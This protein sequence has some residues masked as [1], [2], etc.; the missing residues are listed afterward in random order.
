[1]AASALLFALALAGCRQESL[2]STLELTERAQEGDPRPFLLGF[3]DVP[4]ELTEEAYASQF[5]F[6][7]NYG[8]AILLQR[9]PTWSDFLPRASVSSA[10]RDEVLAAREAARARNLSLVVALDPFDPANRARLDNLP[11]SYEGRSLADPDLRRAFVAEAEFIARNMRPDYL[12]LGTEVN[13]TFE[14]NPEGYFAFVDAYRDAYDVVKEASPQTQVLVTYQYEE[15]LGVVPELPPHAPRWDLL[16]D[17]GARLDVLGITSYPSFA[18]PTARK[19]PAEYYLQLREH[20]DRSVAFVGVGFSSGAH[21]SGV[22]ASTE[23]EQRRFLQRLLEDA[24]RMQSPLLIWFA[25]QDF[26][27]ATTAPYD[28][29]ATIGLRNPNGTP[30]EAWSVWETASRRPVDAEAAAAL[31]AA[32]EAAEAAATPSPTPA[33]EDNGD[34]AGET[35]ADAEET[36]VEGAGDT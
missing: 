7:A 22:N 18:Y 9:P 20:T 16:D 11:A 10:L 5:D 13:T 36:A 30:K 32:Q 28:L 31:L 24:F 23:P 15:L 14:R 12:V 4:S 35:D 1:M 29:L 2:S 21:R 6:V 8:E 19:V 26:G 33:Q 3:S 34:A 25:G 17:L 27:F